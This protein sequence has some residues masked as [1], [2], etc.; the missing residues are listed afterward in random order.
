VARSALHPRLELDLC[1]SDLAFALWACL[2]A[3]ER[4][5]RAA[6]IE[7]GFAR[8]GHALVT[9]SARSGFDLYLAALGLPAG[10]EVLVS[11]LTIAHMAQIAV[12]H[13]LRVVPFALDPD[14]LAPAAGELERRATRHT[15]A[16]LFAHLF[17]ARV[18]LDATASLARERGWLLWED[19]AQAFSG[20]AW[21]GHPRSDLA[22]FSFGLIKTLTALQGGI[23]LVRDRA[24]LARMRAA[25]ARWPVQARADRLRRVLRAML[26]HALARPW[27]FACLARACARL[28]RDLDELLHGATR[29]FPGP[30]FLEA[31]R[32]APSGPLLALLERRLAHPQASRAAERRRTGEERLEAL[33]GAVEVLGRGARERHHW[34]FATGW[35]EPAQLVPR[36][37][38]AGFDATTRSSLVAVEPS[39]GGAAPPANRALLERL[40]YVPLALSATPSEQASLARLLSEAARV[41]AWSPTP[42]RAVPARGAAQP[43]AG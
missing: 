31:L 3:R 25:E 5:R 30:R 38:C 8:A 37:R 24:V 18:D 29:A 12:A 40:L 28:G 17:G 42:A 35:D 2:A 6:R 32:R 36:L 19:C 43:P 13:G 33:G 16:V 9:L 22:L 4:P 14:T 20:D 10:S 39:A 26:L 7:Q 15:R 23:A 21:R 1:A 34:V 41:R 11:G 27:A